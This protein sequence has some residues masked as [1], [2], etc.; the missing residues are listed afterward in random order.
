[1]LAE[2]AARTAGEVLLTRY[3]GPVEGLERKS[4]VTDP[5]SDADRAAEDA[6]RKLLAAE[7]PDDGLLAEEGSRAE[8]ASGRQWIVDPLDGT[9]NYLYGFPA[10]CVSVALRDG[11]GNAVGVV[12]DPL[13]DE[14]FRAARSHGCELNGSPVRV[15]E[16]DDLSRALV[17]TGF[18]YDQERR[19][20]QAEV[21]RRV[22]PQVRDIRRAGAAALDLS[23]LAAGRL[24]GYWERGLRA[25]D[26]AAGRLLVEEAGG[27]VAELPGE[28]Y[29]LVAANP[30]LLPALAALVSA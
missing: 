24:D 27:A 29:G 10:W 8:A 30:A 13:R 6:I 3:G 7:R 25:W 2:R 22:L 17:A 4:S 1:M 20:R 16:R 26:W 15:R 12:R 14:T 21:V 23:W 18:A 5:V 19:T 9:V 11:E 28:P